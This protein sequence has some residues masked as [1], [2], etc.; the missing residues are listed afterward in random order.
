[1]LLRRVIGQDQSELEPTQRENIFQS[2]CKIKKWVYSLIIDGGSNTN[3]ASTRLVE[4]LSLDT[5]PHAKPTSL[6]G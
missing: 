2:R 5:I 1:M 4:K 3:V 6:L